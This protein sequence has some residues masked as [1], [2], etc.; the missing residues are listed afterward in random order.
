[1]AR[2]EGSNVTGQ[3][4][5]FQRRISTDMERK[6]E[7][8]SKLSTEAAP[9]MSS[10][11]RAPEPQVGSERLHE[12]I[13]WDGSECAQFPAETKICQ[14]TSSFATAGASNFITERDAFPEIDG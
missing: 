4:A 5:T 14:S 8:N 7:P 2:E 6:T 13:D 11:C 9:A 3:Q 10:S 12:A 1:M